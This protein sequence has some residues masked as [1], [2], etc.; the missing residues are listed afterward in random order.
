MKEDTLS[1]SKF[2]DTTRGAP[3]RYE[4]IAPRDLSLVSLLL[5]HGQRVHSRRERA[6]KQRA[7]FIVIEIHRAVR[8]NVAEH[9]LHINSITKASCFCFAYIFWHSSVCFCQHLF[10]PSRSTLAPVQR[11]I[12]L[13]Y[14]SSRLRGLWKLF[15]PLMGANGAFSFSHERSNMSEFLSLSPSFQVIAFRSCLFCL[16]WQTS[17]SP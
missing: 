9:T 5:V 4:D 11:P 16:L 6:S 13:I 15:H 8:S 14:L 12:M 10:K 3:A 2:K 1:R 7:W 17:P